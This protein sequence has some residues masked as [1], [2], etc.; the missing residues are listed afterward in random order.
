MVQCKSTPH[1]YWNLIDFILLYWSYRIVWIIWTF[2]TYILL[3]LTRA[4]YSSILCLKSKMF[5][6]NTSGGVPIELTPCSLKI[7]FIWK[8]Q[9]IFK[10]IKIVIFFL[11]DDS[12][13][14]IKPNNIHIWYKNYFCRQKLCITTTFVSVI[15]KTSYWIIVDS[16]TKI[17]YKLNYI[18]K[19][20]ILLLL[21]KYTVV[22]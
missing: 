15:L 7:F 16:C 3:H 12:R 2:I 11:V 20:T 13:L 14:Y 5:S 22:P 10:K 9:W 21:D 6:S 8:S 4:P 18:H 1:G 19:D 17:L